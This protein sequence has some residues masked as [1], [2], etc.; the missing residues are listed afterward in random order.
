MFISSN[1]FLLPELRYCFSLFKNDQ[2]YAMGI[3]HEQ[4]ERVA[5]RKAA[6]KLHLLQTFLVAQDR[7]L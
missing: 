3:N 7:Q 1:K 6:Q 4:T 2:T 5:G